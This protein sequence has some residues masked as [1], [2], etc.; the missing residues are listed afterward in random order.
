MAQVSG[1]VVLLKKSHP[2]QG[3]LWRKLSE[4]QDR[5][6]QQTHLPKG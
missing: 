3:F 4:G 5:S 1:M 6:H 2:S